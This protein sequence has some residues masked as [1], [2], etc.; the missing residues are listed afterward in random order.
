MSRETP[1]L[2]DPTLS[3]VRAFGSPEPEALAALRIETADHPHGEMQ[4]SQEQGQLFR[5]LVS[6]TGARRVL[7][8][9]TFTGYSSQ[10]FADA[11]GP[12]GRVVTVDAD[13][14][15]QHLARSR[16]KAAGLADR[17][18]YIHGDGIAE[19]EKML[20]DRTGWFDLAFLDADKQR[21]VRYCE[22]CLKLLR[23]GG[24]VL[25]D[26]VFRDGKVADP[27]HADDE[28]VRAMWAIR[29]FLETHG[30]VRSLVPISDGVGAFV[31]RQL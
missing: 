25:I 23:P 13:E 11:V 24:L 12:D 27:A 14:T 31:V 20:P 5:L 6:A 7:E 28:G 3:F 29:S 1:Q 17:I 21:V 30:L 9:G 22:L 15:I 19:F 8:A 10:V 2:D 16:A 26:N 4:I 18:E